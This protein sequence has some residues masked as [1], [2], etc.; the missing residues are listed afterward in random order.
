MKVKI[1]SVRLINWKRKSPN[2]KVH[3]MGKQIKSKFKVQVQLRTGF[4]NCL[5]T[6]GSPVY[7]VIW[8][9]SN[10]LRILFFQVVLKEE[11]NL[12]LEVRYKVNHQLAYQLV[13]TCQ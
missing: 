13:I 4:S 1:T 8:V 10:A 3:I 9:K 11:I 12:S 7:R 5:L 6:V 2:L